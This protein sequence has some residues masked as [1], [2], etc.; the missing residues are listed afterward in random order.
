MLRALLRQRRR[1][2]LAGVAIALGVGYLAGALGLLDRIGAGLDE[3]ATVS[4]DDADLVIEGEVAYESS[5]E[6]VR[7]LV[8]SSLVDITA[9]IPGV[10]S[11]SHRLEDVAILLDSEGTPLVTPG[12]SEQPLGVNWPEDPSVS[13]LSFVEGVP[14]LADTEVAIDA[15][16]AEQAGIGTGDT[17]VVA[18]KGKY[19]EYTVTGVVDAAAAGPSEGASLVV[20][21]TPEARL[22]FDR[23]VDDNRIA[24][25]LTEGADPD[26]VA[27]RIAAAAP[28]GVEVVDADTAALHAQ[29]S[30][31]RS[32]AL[33][34]A[35]V[36]GFGVLALAVGMMTVANSLSLLH[37]QRRHLFASFRLV[38]ASVGQL[39]RAAFAE[40]GLLAL[41]ASVVGIPLGLLLAGLIERALGSLG[42]SVPTAG[43]YLTP[44]A[45]LIAV[46]VG[47]VATLVAAWRPVTSA[48]KVSP[49]EAVTEAG[50]PTAARWAGF[51][52][53]VGRAV[54]FAALATGVA[55]LA[56]AEPVG[57]VVAASVTAVV[58]LLLGTLPWLLAQTVSLVMSVVPFR[59]RPLR[60]VAARD[61]ARNPRRTAST[62]AAV[63][64][65]AA[66]VSGLAVFLNSFTDSVDGAVD[67]LVTADLVVD[68]ETFTRGGL[69]SDLVEQLSFV[70]GVD[71]VSGWQLG[72]GTVGQ[73]GVR[74][75]GLDGD[76]ALDVVAPQWQ[77]SE[78]G[79][80]TDTTIWISASLAERTGYSVG[81][82]LPVVFTSGGFEDPTITGVYDTGQA[83]LG[84]AVTDRAVLTRQVPA[85]IDLAA[86]LRTDGTPEA[87]AGVEELAGSYGVTAVLT[88]EQ[89]VDQRAD[90]LRGFQ[91]VIQWMLLFTL[92]QALVGVIN[93]L[94][95]SVGER[96]REFGLLRVSGA[97][98][99]QVL[100]MVLFEGTA[101]AS[102]GTVLGLVIGVGAA[103]A[104]VQLLASLGLD[105][106]SIPVMTVVAIAAVALF[107]GI[108]AAWV[109]ARVAAKVPPLEAIGDSGG[110]VGSRPLPTVTTAEPVSVPAPV[111]VPAAVQPPVAVPTAAP[112][113]FSP[114]PFDPARL[115]AV[116]AATTQHDAVS[117]AAAS[118]AG[119][120]VLGVAVWD[121][122][123]VYAL[124]PESPEAAALMAL[125]ESAAGSG[126]AAPAIA[127]QVRPQPQPPVAPVQPQAAPAPDVP[128]PPAMAQ[129]AAYEPPP[130][131]AEAEIVPEPTPAEVV[132]LPALEE[133]E[134]VSPAPPMQ[135]PAEPPIVPGP[136]IA[137]GDAGAVPP[138]HVQPGEAP[139]VPGGTG[140]PQVPGDD[141]AKGR[142]ARIAA[143]KSRFPRRRARGGRTAN[144]AEGWVAPGTEE[145]QPQPAATGGPV[146]PAAVPTPPVDDAQRRSAELS[147]LVAMLN[148]ESVMRSTEALTGLG[149]ALAPGESLGGVACGRVKAWPA[150][151][152]RTD[153]RLL[154]VVDR[155]G[156]PAIE[157]LHPVAT[158]VLVRPGVGGTV[159]L[160]LVDQGR[161]LEVT[162]VVDSAAAE[163]LVLREA[164]AA[165]QA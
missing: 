27:A 46:G 28:P 68:S 59:P 63:L 141:R 73:F 112:A 87:A 93:T 85:T 42:T 34:R 154:V 142:R 8:P 64:L 32:F 79:P 86:L 18:G 88:P 91:R 155:P 81:D 7:R 83:L 67:E 122:E 134:I 100:R 144:A 161:M 147:A 152:G 41:V 38:G 116:S 119:A 51:G 138:G 9:G 104:A 95:L 4:A 113:A 2:L 31:T 159:I 10:N 107:V 115:V 90:L 160:V 29:E 77:G 80:L 123:T 75:T 148:T 96:R 23:P 117:A 25:T 108:T 149:Q 12:L 40:A 24:V 49:V 102:V 1:L 136:A 22:V 82:T 146:D 39:R 36:T 37:S 133:A 33:V 16:S 21:T 20:L 26:G 74:L 137:S 153:R 129:P 94:V 92:L 121:G 98:R 99:R 5:L 135:P 140:E 14:P 35:L 6:Q 60:R 103:A 132:D 62:T 71:G 13:G 69:P 47:V 53:S 162:D 78:P 52:A 139:Q 157:S 57:V 55:L 72:R 97:S 120:G 89:F 66:V 45:V 48:C 165:P 65:A 101:L 109:P 131:V 125:Y 158:N 70:D 126:V 3:L 106:F 114:P 150:A 58:V 54:V 17:V 61:A 50:S 164:L 19:G 145:T 143:A 30:L 111:A 15:R 44:R 84:D 151:V 105:T 11:V 127:E 128:F 163:A 124:D 43:P 110:D 130:D 76:T 156:R 118:V 56:G